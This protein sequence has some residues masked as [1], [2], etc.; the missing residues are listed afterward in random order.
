MEVNGLQK[1]DTRLKQGEKAA[2]VATI[3]M[4]F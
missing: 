1:K 3:S 4:I 2:K